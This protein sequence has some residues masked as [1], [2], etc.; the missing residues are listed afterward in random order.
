MMLME[1]RD[2]GSTFEGADNEAFRGGRKKAI[3]ID[4]YAAFPVVTTTK[5]WQR[6][7]CD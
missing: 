2:N 1:N 5:R 3:A 4:E 7:A 6:T